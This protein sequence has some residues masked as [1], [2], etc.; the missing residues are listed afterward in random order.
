MSSRNLNLVLVA[1]TPPPT[2]SPPD[3]L[4]GRRSS[5]PP[6]FAAIDPMPFEVPEMAPPTSWCPFPRNVWVVPS[7]SVSI[8]FLVLYAVW[9]FLF[10]VRGWMERR[11]L[12]GMEAASPPGSYAVRV[13]PSEADHIEETVQALRASIEG[14]RRC[15][16]A[17][18]NIDNQLK[19]WDEELKSLTRDQRKRRHSGGDG[20]LGPRWTRKG[21]E[22]KDKEEVCV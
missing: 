2:Y 9:A 3:P 14:H 20:D 10:G 15:V 12:P 6:P 17:E 5:D 8:G 1:G 13:A 11:H 7:L 4:P 19:Q 18:K 16:G 21:N 22:G